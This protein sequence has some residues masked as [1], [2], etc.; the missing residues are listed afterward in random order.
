MGEYLM[1][2]TIQVDFALEQE[3]Q[4]IFRKAGMTVSEAVNDFLR[5]VIREQ[6]KKDDSF[7]DAERIQAFHRLESA[8]MEIQKYYPDGLD[9]EKE[10]TE[11]QIPKELLAL[12][13]SDQKSGSIERNA[14]LLYPYI[15][16]LTISH[17]RAAE[18]LHISK[19]KLIELYDKLGFPYLDQDPEEVEKEL[20][21]FYRAKGES[22]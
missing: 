16:N 1:T 18:I 7:D 3:A 14:L 19:W 11:A 17:G 6:K 12:L 2:S 9:P 10:L 20:E 5:Q 15:Q 13:R 8:W 4:A 21:A 22:A